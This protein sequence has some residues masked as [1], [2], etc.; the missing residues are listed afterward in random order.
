M[1]SSTHWP[2]NASNASHVKK[3]EHKIVWKDVDVLA[4]GTGEVP[5]EGSGKQ[6]RFEA[7]MRRYG[8]TKTLLNMFM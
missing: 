2:A 6:G 4:K 8:T 1:S 5:E 7:G 3:E